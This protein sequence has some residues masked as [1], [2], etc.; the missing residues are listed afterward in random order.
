MDSYVYL[1]AGG[2]DLGDMLYVTTD[3]SVTSTS[4][5]VALAAKTT[6]VALVYYGGH[7]TVFLIGTGVE[8]YSAGFGCC[9]KAADA[10]T[11]EWNDEVA[12]F[13][14]WHESTAVAC[15]SAAVTYDSTKST[16]RVNNEHFDTFQNVTVS[17]ELAGESLCEHWCKC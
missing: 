3:H 10:E 6:W 2:G 11:Y 13:F 16:W 7:H 8:L 12:E 15:L 1:G 17:E 5:H 4:R 14:I 9:S